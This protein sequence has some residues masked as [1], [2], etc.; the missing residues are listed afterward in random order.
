LAI[1]VH[2]EERDGIGLVADGDQMKLIG[3]QGVGGDPNLALFAERADEGEEMM[4]V[5]VGSE[6]GLFVIAALGEMQPLTGWREAK[7]AWHFALRRGKFSPILQK[8]RLD[9]GFVQKQ[10]GKWLI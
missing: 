4:T 7:F 8:K 2:H 1:Q 10:N 6:Y 9:R 3:H 5:L